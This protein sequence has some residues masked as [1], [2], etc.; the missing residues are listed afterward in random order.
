MEVTEQPS[1]PVQPYDRPCAIEVGAWLGRG[2]TG[3]PRRLSL[4]T[5]WKHPAVT[6]A[7]G[8]HDPQGRG[9]HQAVHG[10]R[11]RG[12]RGARLAVLQ[13]EGVQVPVGDLHGNRGDHGQRR[14]QAPPDRLVRGGCG[15][16][17]L[18]CPFGTT[19]PAGSDR[20]DFGTVDA[21]SPETGKWARHFTSR[22]RGRWAWPHS[23]RRRLW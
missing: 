19:S 10:H 15:R 20:R 17:L 22:A 11:Q 1:M 3:R 13:A 18:L 21:T 2:G 6:G 23:A 12:G 16:D 8:V 7:A 4:A 14:H 9:Q 5:R